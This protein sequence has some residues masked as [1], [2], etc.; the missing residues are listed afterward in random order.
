MYLCPIPD[1]SL[2]KGSP[3]GHKHNPPVDLAG[4]YQLNVFNARTGELVIPLEY[5]LGQVE[6]RLTFGPGHFANLYTKETWPAWGLAREMNLNLEIGRNGKVTTSYP[7]HA[8]Y[9]YG[10]D[11]T[12]PSEEVDKNQ[13]LGTAHQGQY[14]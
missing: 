2:D 9:N 8:I 7:N 12:I 1:K 6:A 3:K 14:N 4:V 5:S 11:F 13:C 10:P